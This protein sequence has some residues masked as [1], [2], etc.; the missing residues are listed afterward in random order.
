MPILKVLSLFVSLAGVWLASV[1]VVGRE[2]EPEPAMRL[3]VLPS[4]WT[5]EQVDLVMESFNTSLGVD[6]AYCHPE[7]P[8][9]PPRAPG[10]DPVLDYA[11]DS[12]EE[13]IASRFMITLT[14]EINASLEDEIVSCYTCHLGKSTPAFSPSAGW[15]RA[16]FTLRPAGP[17]VPAN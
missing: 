13:K 16:R 17:T 12:K 15:G 10:E 8:E 14:N 6:C 7:D 5:R 9:A 2:Q 3:E 1:V 11:D 4:T